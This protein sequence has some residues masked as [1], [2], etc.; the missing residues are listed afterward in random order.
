MH[1]PPTQRYAMPVAQPPPPTNDRVPPIHHPQTPQRV[2]PVDSRS[3]Q[4]PPLAQRRE[5]PYGRTPPHYER[6][7]A[8]P[9]RKYDPQQA[10]PGYRPTPT[11]PQSGQSHRV[12]LHHQVQYKHATMESSGTHYATRP[13]DRSPAPPQP[14]PHDPSRHPHEVPRRADYPNMSRT[15]DTRSN[16]HYPTPSTSSV[17]YAPTAPTAAVPVVQS[18]T[19]PTRAVHRSATAP[20]LNYDYPTSNQV[21]PSPARAA[22]KPGYPNQQTRMTVSVTSLVNQMNQTKQKRESPLDLSVKTVKNSAD[23]STTQDDMVDS[24]MENKNLPLQP[25]PSSSTRQALVAPGFVDSHKVDFS[26]DFT[27]YRERSHS[28]SHSYSTDALPGH[29]PVPYNGSYEAPRPAPEPVSYP[30]E[31]R[32][33]VYPERSKYSTPIAR[34]EYVPRIDL[35]RPISDE[36]RP[37]NRI[38]DDRHFII[39]ERKRPAGP[40]VSNI[41]EKILRYETWTSDSRLDRMSQSAREQHE[42]IS[43]PVYSYSCHKQFEAYQNEQKR[44]TSSSVYRELHPHTNHRYPYPVEPSTRE[45]GD[46]HAHYHDRTP[47]GTNRHVIQKIPSHRETH[48]HHTD[49]HSDVPADKRILSILRKSLEFKQTGLVEPAR[50]ARQIPD[51][52]VIDDIDDTVIEITDLTKDNDVEGNRSVPETVHNQIV[53][54]MGHHIQMPKAVDSLPRDSDYQRIDPS[55][56]KSKSPENDVASRI[57]TK[58][59]L[60]VLPPSQDSSMRSDLKQDMNCENNKFKLLPK[61][62]KQHLFNQIRQDLRLE[63]VIKS[64]NSSE[65]IIPVKSEPMNIEEIEKDAVI[66]IKTEHIIESLETE[67]VDISPNIPEEDLD[68]ASACDSFMEQLKTGSHKRK[69]LRK[70]VDTVDRDSDNKLEKK[71][72]K[73]EP[74]ES[75]LETM[76]NAPS[77]SAEITTIAPTT[78]EPLTDEPATVVIKQEP[79]DEDEMIGQIE[80]SPLVISKTTDDAKEISEK[81]Q[82]LQD[83]QNN[84]QEASNVIESTK[85]LVVQD[86]KEEINSSNE[87]EPRTKDKDKNKIK[88]SVVLGENGKEQR[89]SKKSLSLQEEKGKAQAKIRKT[90]SLLSEKEKHQS[91]VRK[92]S[93]NQDTEK[94]KAQ[95]T[96]KTST[97]NKKDKN[98]ILDKNEKN[99][100]GKKKEKANDKSNK[101]KLIAKTKVKV[102]KDDSTLSVKKDVK[103]KEPVKVVVKEELESTDDDEPLIKSKM[104]KEKEIKYQLLKD[105]S[106]KSAYVKLECFDVDMNKNARISIDSL[107]KDKE[108]KQ[109][110]GKLTRQSSRT[111]GKSLS[112]ENIKSET[113]NDESSTDS[114]DE[115]LTVAIASRLRVR[116]SIKTEDKIIQNKTQVKSSPSKKQDSSS[117]S[118]CSTPVRKPGFGDGSDFHPGW[119]EELYK[120]KRSLRMPTRLIAIPHGRSGGPFVRGSGALFTRGSSSLPD[121]DPAPLSPAPSSS[122]SAATDDLYA[123][124]PDKQNLDSDLESNSSSS[125]LNRLHYDSEASTSTVFSSNAKK[126]SSSIVDVLIQKC[127]RKDDSKKKIKDKDELNKTPK[128]IP[129]SSNANELL[130]TPSLGLLKNGEKGNLSAKKEKLMEDIFYLGAFRKET[131]TAF[132]NAF[133]K[134]TDGLIGATEEFAPV[135]LKSRTRTE[136]RVLKQRATIKEVFGD[137][138]PAS[139]PPTSCREEEPQEEAQAVEVKKEPEPESEQESKAKLKAKKMMKDKLKRR[140]SSIRDGLRS[141]KSLKRNDAKGRLLRLKKRNSLLKSISNKRMKDLSGNKIKKEKTDNTPDEKDKSKEEGSSPGTV[142]GNTKRR[143]KRLFGRRKF[144]S[145]FDYIR[146]KKKIIRREDTPN[147]KIRRPAVKPSPESVHDIQKEIKGW[148]INKSVGETHLH[149]AARLGYTVGI[150]RY[151]PFLVHMTLLES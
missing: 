92:S 2:N 71:T 74:T 139:A 77:T 118:N 144:S 132:R 65:A 117:T 15:V 96:L 18:S 48:P 47:S 29:H 45:R 110:K 128:I 24:A 135:V 79:I 107:T 34:P 63:S 41:P 57:R 73:K 21:Q 120:Y 50:Q 86:S 59:E 42:L 126:K 88:K 43:R 68:W 32:H 82:N 56:P 143:L 52:I 97:S 106:E 121:L 35:T 55:D 72:P 116:K 60:K 66:P 141:T 25:R 102:E 11:A 27:Q 138:R 40:I 127:G 62:Q 123:R 100:I 14:Y 87:P 4:Y 101:D 17:R 38:R 119:E 30:V 81:S 37:E 61:S 134:N 19:L 54:N 8:L 83:T 23:S 114:E 109:S 39:E 20:K 5:S 99:K 113:P 67:N 142:E 28:S 85:L 150:I 26:P 129:K 131:V 9:Q 22:V 33:P 108:E 112:I 7:P 70:R 84:L 76:V 6:Y 125:V 124:R 151:Q 46:Y 58:A 130:A 149:R 80:P 146:K 133:I 10:Y 3:A 91:K 64:E 36:R 49:L 137:E 51:L 148:F 31:S 122:Q 111:K 103:E 1:S 95:V 78:L 105:L 12:E 13:M 145:G 16:Y 147:N 94:E 136:S 140:S 75:I 89:K 98:K 69:S 115:N 53:P 44:A 93:S 90:S 104:L